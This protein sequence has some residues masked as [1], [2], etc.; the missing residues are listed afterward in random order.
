MKHNETDCKDPILSTKSSSE[1]L[2]MKLSTLK[3]KKSHKER[4]WQKGIKTN[5]NVKSKREI[6]QLPT[7]TSK[8]LP[9][10]AAR[11]PPFLFY[12]SQSSHTQLTKT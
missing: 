7:Q 1:N 6:R 2:E 4:E 12:E 9:S 8:N 10:T 3:P 11:N 5:K